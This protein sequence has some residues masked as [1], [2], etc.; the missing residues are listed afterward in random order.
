MSFVRLVPRMTRRKMQRRP[1]G[2]RRIFHME[3]R[4]A[5]IGFEELNLACDPSPTEVIREQIPPH[6][7]RGTKER[8]E[9]QDDSTRFEDDSLAFS[10]VPPVARQ[11]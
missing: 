8:G 7:R 5:R 2:S 1:E 9:A 6:P 3:E 11:R 4:P 10:L